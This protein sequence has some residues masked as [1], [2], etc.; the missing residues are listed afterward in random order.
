MYF[1]LNS[2]INSFDGIWV[3]KSIGMNML[4]FVANNTV[5]E[6][7]MSLVYY[8]DTLEYFGSE[9]NLSYKLV[10]SIHNMYG[11]NDYNFGD[12]ENA[13][14]SIDNITIM[15]DTKGDAGHFCNIYEWHLFNLMP[16][17]I[18]YGIINQD[19]I[20]QAWSIDVTNYDYILIE[21]N[22]YLFALTVPT[23]ANIDNYFFWVVDN[24]GNFDYVTIQIV[25]T[26][27][28]IWR[29][30]YVVI[31]VLIGIGLV[32]GAD[33]LMDT[34]TNLITVIGLTAIG[35]TFIAVGVMIALDISGYW[36]FGFGV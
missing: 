15:I 14:G 21:A 1:K 18:G 25:K 10:D 36:H 28:D 12:W 11:D 4:F 6:N 16:Y 22:E 27:N 32:G 2:P 13:F 35:I 23:N 33:L 29:W 34:K 26:N 5:G 30:A 31:P 7:S 19:N 17:V 9:T 3:K 20:S 24:K 8:T